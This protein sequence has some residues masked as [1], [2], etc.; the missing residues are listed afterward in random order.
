MNGN[1]SYLYYLNF[2]VD[3][4]GSTDPFGMHEKNFCFAS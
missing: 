3:E 2:V 1:I 4:V